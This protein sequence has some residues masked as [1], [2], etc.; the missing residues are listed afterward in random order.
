[1]NKWKWKNIGCHSTRIFRAPHTNG[2]PAYHICSQKRDISSSEV[3]RIGDDEDSSRTLVELLSWGRGSAGQLGG[4]VEETRFYPC[5]VLSMTV[6]SNFRFAPMQGLLREKTRSSTS[7]ASRVV[8]LGISCGLFHSSL[9]VDGKLYVWGKGD[10]GRLG[11]GTEKTMYEPT[12]NSYLDPV[13]SVALGGLHSAAVTAQGKLFTWGY[14]GFGALGHSVY[15]RELI[16]KQVRKHWEGKIVYLA[17]SGAHT[18]AICDSGELYT[19][20]RDEGEGRL[21]LGSEGGPDEGALGSPTRVK[22]LPVP[23]AAVS[24]GGFFT[25]A[26]TSEGQVW[27]WGGNSNFE[28]GRGTSGSDWRPRPIPGLEGVRIVQIAT[29]GFHS[30]ALTDDGKVFSWGHGGHGQLGHGSVQN[31]RVPQ[32]VEALADEHIVYLACGSLS[33]AVVT[34]SGKLYMWGKGR[35]HQLGVPG[36]PDAQLLPALVNFLVENEELGPAHVLAV[37]AGASHAMCLLSRSPT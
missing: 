10:G 12:L 36:L 16:P 29:G 9:L 31:G 26:L 14:G 30:L 17:T 23:I 19:W 35:D 5:R 2:Y 28:L 6:P 34:D 32:V 22:E 27:S 37:A 25:L 4:G 1:M 8:E 18:A 11:L 15:H 13:E 24:C 20:G 33:S 21:G 3:W 7:S